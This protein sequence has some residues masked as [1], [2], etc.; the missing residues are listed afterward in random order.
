MSPE[1]RSRRNAALRLAFAVTVGLIVELLRGAALPILAPLIAVQL[2]A[3]IP[4]PPGLK[5]VVMLA[6]VTAVSSGVAYLVAILTV[7]Q[8]FL[9]ALGVGLLYLWGFTL[10]FMP[11]LGPVGVMSVTMTIV[12]TG[13]ATASSDVALGIMVSLTKSIVIGFF[14]VL[15]AHALLPSKV[16]DAPGGAAPPDKALESLPA[17]ARAMIATL[18]I[19]PAHLY[20]FAHGTGSMLVLMTVATMLRQPGLNASTRYSIA[21]ASGNLVGAAVAAVAMLLVSVQPSFT[22][23]VSSTA[24]CALFLAWMSARGPMWRAVMIPGIAAFV[25]LYGIVYSPYVAST[26]VSVLQ[27]STMVVTGAVYALAAV[28]VLIPLVPFIRRWHA[29]AM[30]A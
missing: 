1:E 30:T 27:R 9:Y 20:L 6:G 18:V 5:L 2:V 22:V 29:R 24:A 8:P 15:L 19:L 14:I 26:E 17:S 23:M 11:R 13:L 28:S 7:G 25:L 10:T 12:V 4:R 21:F 3:A 16:V